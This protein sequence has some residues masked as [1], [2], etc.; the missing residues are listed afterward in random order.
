MICLRQKNSLE[1]LAKVY[2]PLAS[3]S[4]FVPYNIKIKDKK[5]IPSPTELYFSI[6]LESLPSQK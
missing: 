2:I 6:I 4:P 3:M 1:D 5:N